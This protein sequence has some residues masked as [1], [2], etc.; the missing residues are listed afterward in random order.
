MPEITFRPVHRRKR[1]IVYVAGGLLIPVAGLAYGLMPASA[2]SAGAITGLAGKCI[3]VAASGTAN[4]TAVQLYDCNGTGAQIW[5]V[6]N[7]DGSLRALGK[8]LDVTAAGTAD[9]TSRVDTA[10]RVFLNNGN[11]DLNTPLTFAVYGDQYHIN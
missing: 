6:G 8:C 1:T 7:A 2:A 9:G 11:F 3:D 4:G 10:Q 5:T